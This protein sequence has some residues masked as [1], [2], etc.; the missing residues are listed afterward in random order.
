MG[1][2]AM[3]ET[4][5]ISLDLL[6]NE[7]KKI[8]EWIVQYF[9]NIEDVRVF[10][11]TTPEE[12]RAALQ[13]PLPKDPETL[14]KIFEDFR[15]KVVPYLTHWNHP[16]F[17][18][19]FANT[20]SGPGILAETL[21]AALNVNQMLWR[22]APSASA[23]E[24]VV[25]GWVKE[26]LGYP[27]DADGVLMNGASWASL[28]AMTAALHSLPGLEIR[29]RGL[30]SRN[31]PRLRIYRSDQAHSSIDRAALTLGIG[32]DNVVKIPCD[33]AYRLRPS[34]LEEAVAA[35]QSRGYLPFFACGTVGTTSTTSIDPIGAV[36]E[37]CRRFQLWLHVDAAYAGFA[38]IVPEVKEKIGDFSVADSLVV[39]PHKWL[40]S[41]MEI[42]CLFCRRQGALVDTFSLVPEYLRSEQEPVPN[43]MDYSPQ[44]G[45][46]FRALKLW[47]VIR[48]FG[49]E[50][51]RR[52]LREHIRIAQW[53]AAQV[54]AHPDFDRVAPV[55]FS[56]VCFRAMATRSNLFNEK[57][58]GRINQTGKVFLSHTRLDEKYTLRLAIG[59][60]RTEQRHVAAAWQIIQEE[61]NR[62]QRTAER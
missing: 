23:L 38:A 43:F 26:M 47:Y 24:E 4:G 8:Y 32:L 33:Q 21:T 3:D 49:L 45:R 58:L 55:E 13:A 50:G 51:L 59:N 22:T 39:N 34:L 9:R 41:P 46:S 6:E 5:D 11:Q 52:R 42:T 27:S 35:D 53:F 17:L 44:L 12:L 61:A 31:L 48:S 14:D 20:G 10:P 60:I 28:T 56:T 16:N 15:A 29:R 54:D 18:A 7:G 37:I 2:C 1:R 19:Y 36:A 62:L 40:F 30:A 25:L 57:L